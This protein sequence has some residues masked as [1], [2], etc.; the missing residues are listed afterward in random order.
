MQVTQLQIHLLIQVK[1]DSD[2]NAD[3]A[4]LVIT[5]TGVDDD[6]TGVND[7][8]SVNEDATLSVNTSSGVLSN[9]TDADDASS[10]S[11]SAISGGTVGS[12]LTGDYGDLTLN[13][14]GSYTYVANHDDADALDPGDTDT[15]VFT[16]TVSDGAGTTDTA[17]LT[18]TVTGVNDD[19]VAVDDTDAVTEN[20]SL[21][22]ST[23]DAQELD[24]DDTD[25]DDDDASGSFTITAIRHRS[26]VWKRHGWYSRL[27]VDR[28]LWCSNCSFNRCI[29]IC[30]Q[31]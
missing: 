16:Y 1:D 11:V 4:E 20:G 12:A 24:H 21:N 5:V 25:A 8:G 10:L 22:R 19:I 29:Y 2:K 3:T 7:T 13:A 15:D 6:P 28:N 9:D 17:T 18:I 31:Y 26:R 14:N 27:S 23:S 30:C